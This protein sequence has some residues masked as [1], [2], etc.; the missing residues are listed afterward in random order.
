MPTEYH[1][2]RRKKKKRI[3]GLY[4][5]SVRQSITVWIHNHKLGYD[6]GRK[7]PS[8]HTSSYI[9]C[10]LGS[11]YTEVRQVLT[12]VTSWQTVQNF[13]YTRYTNY[14]EWNN[15]QNQ[16]IIQG[17]VQSR[18]LVYLLPSKP[19]RMKWKALVYWKTLRAHRAIVVTATQE[20]R[21]EPWPN[22]IKGQKQ[23]DIFDTNS[24]ARR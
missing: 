17:L 8:R 6:Q 2:I 16:S 15:I 11:I 10:K 20:S 13:I 18:G 12:G 22:P 4:T 14:Q 23:A 19:V 24:G 21:S 5:I 9:E 3:Y 7:E 1:K